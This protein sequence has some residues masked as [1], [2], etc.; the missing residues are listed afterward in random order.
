MLVGVLLSVVVVVGDVVVGD[1][2]AGAVSLRFLGVAV[3]RRRTGVECV[4]RCRVTVLTWV[5]VW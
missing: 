5:A 3:G 2:V 4:C 1:V